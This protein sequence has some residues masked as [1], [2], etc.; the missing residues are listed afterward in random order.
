MRDGTQA[1]S[2]FRRFGSLMM[3]HFV[4]TKNEIRF[5]VKKN[6]AR[7]ASALACSAKVS[8]ANL[9]HFALRKYNP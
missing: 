7:R 5:M 9:S 1:A 3:P 8:S 4:K 6:V 2:I